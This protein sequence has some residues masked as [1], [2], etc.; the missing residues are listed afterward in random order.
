[1]EARTDDDAPTDDDDSDALEPVDPD[2]PEVSANATGIAANPEP[3][4]KATANAPT[5][6]TYRE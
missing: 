5:R 4:P 2:D 6:P 3:T 1:M